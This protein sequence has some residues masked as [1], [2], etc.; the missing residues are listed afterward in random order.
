MSCFQCFR[1]S[2]GHSPRGTSIVST[3]MSLKTFDLRYKVEILHVVI[4]K[5]DL[6]SCMFLCDGHAQASHNIGAVLHPP[7]PLILNAISKH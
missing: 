5:V 3:L 4:G 6:P 7:P 1:Y 2:C